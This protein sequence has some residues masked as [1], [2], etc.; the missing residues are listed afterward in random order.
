MMVTTLFLIAPLALIASVVY[1]YLVFSKFRIFDRIENIYIK[2]IIKIIT[3]VFVIVI[4]TFILSVIAMV[5]LLGIIGIPALIIMDI[6]GI[7]LIVRRKM[8]HKVPDCSQKNT[9]HSA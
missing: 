7:V 1:S 3:Y 2:V 6:I 4:F 8:K 9:P 5:L